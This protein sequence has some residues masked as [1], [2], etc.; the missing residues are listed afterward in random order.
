MNSQSNHQ[1]WGKGIIY[2]LNFFNETKKSDSLVL[3]LLEGHFSIRAMCRQIY[4]EK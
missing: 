2:R 1:C 3:A 4:H